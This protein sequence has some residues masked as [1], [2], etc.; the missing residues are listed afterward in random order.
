[1]VSETALLGVAAVALAMV[2]TPGP[3]MMYLVSRSITQ[4]RRAGLISLGGVAVGFLVYL[5]ATNLGL[6]AVFVAVPEL[7]LTVKLAGACYLGWLAWKALRP[8]GTSV[9]APGELAQDSPR[10]L[11]AM[12]LVTN[13][14]NPKA[15]VMYLSLI[16]QFVHPAAGHVLLQG[17]VLGGTQ[18]AVSMAVNLL[19][20]LAAGTIALFRA[21]RPV[22]L[23]VQRYLMGTVLGGLALKLATDHAR[24][25][26]A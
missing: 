1:V 24:P 19:I 5:T 20:V 18:L 25:A 21:R 12:G 14:L 3:N 8:N 2:L 16:P 26:T 4:G 23:R 6:A 11:F 13:L 7:Y 22:W 10:R 15:A 9:F 17:F